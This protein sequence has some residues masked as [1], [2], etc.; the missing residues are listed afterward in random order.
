MSPHAQPGPVRD[1]TERERLTWGTCPVCSAPHGEFCHAAV[2]LQLGVRADGRPPQDGDGA[3]LA[4]LNQ[5]PQRVREVP[6]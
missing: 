5:T 1:L 2:G 3:H 6:A 4:R